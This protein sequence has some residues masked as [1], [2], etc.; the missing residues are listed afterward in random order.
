MVLIIR[1]LEIEDII[2]KDTKYFLLNPDNIEKYIL[3][4]S[5]KSLSNDFKAIEFKN[6]K[7]KNTNILSGNLLLAF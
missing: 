6:K 2:K 7:A 3:N 1:T 4:K 5:K